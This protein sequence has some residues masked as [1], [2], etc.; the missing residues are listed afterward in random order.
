MA[1][2]AG[3]VGVA[4]DQVDE[5]GKIVGSGPS[6]EYYT[7]SQADNKFETKSHVNNTFQKMELEVPIELLNGSVLT[8]VETALHGMNEEFSDLP[9]GGGVDYSTVEQDTGIKFID[10]KE[11]YQKCYVFS[12]GSYVNIGSSWTTVL[13]DIDDTDIETLVDCDAY[14]QYNNQGGVGSLRA[15]ALLQLR[16]NT[17]SSK[18]VL[19]CASNNATSECRAIMIRYTKVGS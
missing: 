6:G 14:G 11:I 13:S 12:Q 7:K 17:S 19:E 10:G 1:L 9:T 4:K 3:R 18:K 16:W 2:K 5:F 15:S 8:T